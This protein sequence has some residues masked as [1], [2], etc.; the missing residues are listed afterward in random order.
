[1]RNADRDDTICQRCCR[2]EPAFITTSPVPTFGV[3]REQAQF[4][5]STAAKPVLKAALDRSN[6]ED[7][8]KNFL[9]ERAF[10]VANVR[11]ML[12]ACKSIGCVTNRTGARLG[13][14]FLIAGEWLGLGSAGPVFVTNAHVICNSW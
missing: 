9:G 12:D 10:S 1:L 3:A 2:A 8:E 6:Q 13:T 14:G 5:I 11:D 7:L 4:T